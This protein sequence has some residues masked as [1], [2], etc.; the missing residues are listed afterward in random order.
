MGS[1]LLPALGSLAS[2]GPQVPPRQDILSCLPQET[3]SW[4]HSPFGM[5]AGPNPE[6]TA[7]LAM[8]TCAGPDPGWIPAA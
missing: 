3:S 5:D 4:S 6:H 2:A 7:L 1:L 8:G